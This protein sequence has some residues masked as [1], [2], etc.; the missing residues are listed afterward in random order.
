MSLDGKLAD[1]YQDAAEGILDDSDY[2]L[3][4]KEYSHRKKELEDEKQL[5]L[6]LDEESRKKGD[7]TAA[8]SR[9]KKYQA[10]KTLS[11]ELVEC[12]VKLIKIYDGKRVEVRLLCRDEIMEKLEG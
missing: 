5:L 8:H 1:L 2:L 6:R 10:F 9:I 11:R 12:F 3:M 4:R 7:G